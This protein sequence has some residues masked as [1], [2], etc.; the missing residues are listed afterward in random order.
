MSARLRVGF[1]SDFIAGLDDITPVATTLTEQQSAIVLQAVLIL[2]NRY[3][4]NDMTDSE[5]YALQSKLAEVIEKVS[6]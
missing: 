5:W 3:C 2:L 6:V 4:W 1:D